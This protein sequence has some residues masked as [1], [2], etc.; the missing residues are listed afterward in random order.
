MNMH[1]RNARKNTSKTNMLSTPDSSL[2]NTSGRTFE[3]LNAGCLEHKT[4]LDDAYAMWM[5]SL[6]IPVESLECTAADSCASTEPFQVF[7]LLHCNEQSPVP[8]EI[9]LT[10][11]IS[12]GCSK[13]FVFT[14]TE[15]VCV[16]YS[17]LRPTLVSV[18]LQQDSNVVTLQNVLANK[19]NKT[20][21]LMD[22]SFF[23]NDSSQI[24]VARLSKEAEKHTLQFPCYEYQRGAVMQQTEC[25]LQ[26][27]TADFAKLDNRPTVV[28]SSTI[29][30]VSRAEAQTQRG[31]L[32]R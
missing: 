24:V 5:T 2:P 10:M 22:E 1:M 30:L 16:P 15:N 21:T 29:K 3:H 11:K 28:P 6:Q 32:E 27:L 26:M 12:S 18:R 20:M 8:T 4:S 7:L 19:Q 13:N 14:G 9:S 31:K 23:V 25:D 17:K